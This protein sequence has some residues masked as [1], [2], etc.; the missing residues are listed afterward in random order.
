MS[1]CNIIP[2]LSGFFAVNT[3]RERVLKEKEGNVETC[4]NGPWAGIEP[5]LQVHI[6]FCTCDYLAQQQVEAPTGE[7]C[8]VTLIVEGFLITGIHLRPL[9]SVFLSCS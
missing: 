7:V 1:E 3:D 9:S 6:G 2:F 4:S 8:L 5:G